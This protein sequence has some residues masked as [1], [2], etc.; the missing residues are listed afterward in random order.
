MVVA[1]LLL[2]ACAVPKGS[3][4]VLENHNGTEFTMKFNKWSE[5]SKCEMSLEKDDEFQIDV[6]RDDGEITLTISGKNGSEPYTGNDLQSG[7]F[8][9]TVAETDEYVIRIT[10]NDATGNVTIKNLGNKK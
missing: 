2:S 3:I 1:I 5:K 6:S 4:V 7:I 9:V 10:G 8:S